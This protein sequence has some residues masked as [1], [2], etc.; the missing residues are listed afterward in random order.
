MGSAMLPGPS[1]DRHN[2]PRSS[3]RSSPSLARTINEGGI[4][5]RTISGIISDA[6]GFS[7]IL[8]SDKSLEFA[9]QTVMLF[10]EVGVIF[11][12]S[13]KDENGGSESVLKDEILSLGSALDRLEEECSRLREE[14][15]R[16][17]ENTTAEG[18]TEAEWSRLV[19]A[20]GELRLKYQEAQEE[21][22]RTRAQVETE[23]EEFCQ[24]NEEFLEQAKLLESEREEMRRVK[25]AMVTLEV[26]TGLSTADLDHFRRHFLAI[27]D[28]LSATASELCEDTVLS[29]AQADELRRTRADLDAAKKELERIRRQQSVNPAKTEV[30]RKN[31]AVPRPAGEKG[32]ELPARPE[33]K[34]KTEVIPKKKPSD[35]GGA[36]CRDGR[37]GRGRD[38]EILDSKDLGC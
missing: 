28:Q 20:N 3:L 10:H 11:F 27:Q 34:S 1:A 9:N 15:R 33:S 22:R 18:R 12:H 8:R 4:P 36:G 14:N 24:L 21:I 35:S 37:G 32:A 26:I 13:M 16:L 19:T 29:R 7:S 31:R 5:V 38:T 6:R 23:S 30:I 25:D 2:G 17:R